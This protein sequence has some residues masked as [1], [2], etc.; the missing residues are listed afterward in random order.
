M[1]TGTRVSG[2]KQ[3]LSNLS[4]LGLDVDDFKETFGSIADRGAALAAGFVRSRSGR[5][6]GTVRGNRAKNRSVVSAGRA[7]VKYAG[8]QNY[9]WPRRNIPAQRF[10]QR[11]DDQLKPQVPTLLEG[12]LQD[13][14]KRRGLA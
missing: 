14:I 7:S 2:L 11:A 13:K 12:E 6:A 3:V 10:M 9:G 5:L 1:A 8:V 4:K